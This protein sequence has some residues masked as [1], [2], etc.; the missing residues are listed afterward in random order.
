MLS[1]ALYP[2]NACTLAGVACS[3]LAV[4]FATG[5]QVQL[6]AAAI[7]WA[8]VFDAVDGVVARR[9]P[10]RTATQG[11]FGLYLD[12]LADVVSAGMAVGAVLILVGDRHPVFVTAAVITVCAVAV[13]LAYFT[14]HGLEGDHFVGVPVVY[15]LLAFGVVALLAPFLPAG[16][17]AVDLLVAN[18]LV[19]VGNV[20]PLRTP[21]P[22]GRGLVLLV[23]VCV[24]LSA[25]HVVMV[26]LR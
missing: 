2:A 7:L 23:T 25:V 20:A 24:V 21:K 19:V 12:S 3:V 16:V 6:A 15:N 13:R 22:R 1:Y 26:I 10:H 9:D 17:F 18:L 11:Q 4:Y 8:A 5:G 14:A